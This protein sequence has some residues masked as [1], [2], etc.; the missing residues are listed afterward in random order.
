MVR[1]SVDAFLY[2]MPIV[3]GPDKIEL[4]KLS[5]LKTL[6]SGSISIESGITEISSELEIP[7]SS[8]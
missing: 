8:V 4:K 7:E 5:L 6:L 3:L 2:C 1:I